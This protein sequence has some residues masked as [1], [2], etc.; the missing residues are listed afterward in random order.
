MTT[1]RI[2]Q[3]CTC[4]KVLLVD[5]IRCATS[6]EVAPSPAPCVTV[7]LANTGR[8]LHSLPTGLN[9]TP[10]NRSRSLRLCSFAR[11]RKTVWYKYQGISQDTALCPPLGAQTPLRTAL[12]P[13]RLCKSVRKGSRS[14]VRWFRIVVLPNGYQ[15]GT[16]VLSYYHN[17][18]V[19][20]G[21]I[22]LHCQCV[23]EWLEDSSVCRSQ[24]PHLQSQ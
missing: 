8:S 13:Y 2:N 5:R 12:Y 24:P 19:V 9:K 18:T 20:I 6:V 16:S 1:G 7:A 22:H 4:G 11:A 3:V 21:S 17:V 10:W 14:R 23:N 15:Y